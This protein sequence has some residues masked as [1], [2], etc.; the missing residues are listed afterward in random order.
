[1]NLPEFAVTKNLKT[2]RDVDGTCI[3]PGRLGESHVYECAPNQLG[4]LFQPT[5]APTDQ[6]RTKLWN[7]VRKKC[8]AA[9]MTLRQ[10]GDDEGALSFDPENS[11]QAKLA[12]RC[13]KAR[14]RRR[15]SAAQLAVLAKARAVRVEGKAARFEGKHC[16]E[17]TLSL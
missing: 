1:M 2:K 11:E 5:S 3:I 4:V 13:I 15:P 6:P 9:G 7:S 17:G 16:A 8:I 10:N 14:A 12:V